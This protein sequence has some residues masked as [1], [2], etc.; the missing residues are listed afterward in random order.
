MELAEV[1]VAGN[2]E[3]GRLKF[4]TGKEIELPRRLVRFLSP[5]RTLLLPLPFSALAHTCLRGT[6]SKRMATL[7]PSSSSSS[8]SYAQ[9]NGGSGNVGR[10]DSRSA[11]DE[12]SK[13][14]SQES[15]GYHSCSQSNE[16]TRGS[17][18]V[19]RDAREVST[20]SRRVVES[21]LASISASAFR[22]R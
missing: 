8:S 5:I 16:R 19:A 12:A 13:T 17:G 21:R 7:R 4:I 2:V 3:N 15:E 14:S 6:P 1:T 20:S 9:P 22:Q 11:G 10:L 18:D